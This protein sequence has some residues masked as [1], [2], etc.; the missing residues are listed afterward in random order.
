MYAEI[1]AVVFEESS[2]VS[3]FDYINPCL[4]SGF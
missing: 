4:K 1:A 2:F 3:S